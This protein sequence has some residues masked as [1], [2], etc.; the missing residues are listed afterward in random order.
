M[1]APPHAGPEGARHEA[2]QVPQARLL[3]RDFMQPAARSGRRGRGATA[4]GGLYRG[5]GGRGGRLARRPLLGVP[6]LRRGGVFLTKRLSPLALRAALK[7]A[8]ARTPRGRQ[9]GVNPRCRIECRGRVSVWAWRGRGGLPLP[10]VLPASLHLP[11]GIPGQSPRAAVGLAG[12]LGRL[13]LPGGA[14]SPGISA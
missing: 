3:L 8:F 7:C 5:G 11:L 9:T 12:P 13:G 1:R 14:R 2:Q 10:P 4:A 6:G